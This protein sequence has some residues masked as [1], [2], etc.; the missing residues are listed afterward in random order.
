[1]RDFPAVRFKR[2]LGLLLGVF[3]WTAGTAAAQDIEGVQ[4][5][6]LDQPRINLIARRQ[7]NGPVLMVGGQAAFNVEAFLDTGASGIMLSPHTAEQLGIKRQTTMTPAGKPG[8][9]VFEDVGVGGG[10][11]FGV[12]EP[13]YF[14]LAAYS[15]ATNT[16][17]ADAIPAT[18]VQTIGPFRAEIGPLG[19]KGDLLTQLAMADLDVA[20]MPAMR[21]KIVVLNVK[22]VNTFDDTIRTTLYDAKNAPAGIATCKRHI[23]LS[24]GS[25]ARFTHLSPP[26]AQPPSMAENPFIGPNPVA[27]VIGDKTPAMQ[28]M[29]HGKRIS[30]SW[31]LDTGAAASMISLANAQALGVTYVD[32]TFGTDHPRLV[33]V[34]ADQQFTL[35]VGGIGGSKKS[36][37]FFLD[38]LRLTTTEGQPLV[39]KKA[40]VLV[41]D[42]TVR[43]PA[44]GRT[45]TLDGV[46]GM[47]FLTASCMVDEGGLIPDMKNMTAG[48]FEKVVID[49]QAGVLGLQ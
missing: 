36:A 15:P 4:P 2:C 34:P 20:G 7:A 42:I 39:F 32:G 33:G 28:A 14:S 18:Y 9:V 31:L 5:A 25:F 49:H 17:D 37:G 8:A 48:A 46:F 3:L 6:A 26:N 10:D 19:D 29:H 13:L 40:P 27:A 38:E 21:D 23:K 43:D 30:G 12:S 11:Q 16:Y 24:Y 47:N 35:T 41:S 45:L 1:M 44:T 22:P